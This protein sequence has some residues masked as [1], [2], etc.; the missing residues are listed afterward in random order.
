[1]GYL[2]VR[3]SHEPRY[4]DIGPSPTFAINA[5][6]SRKTEK[7]NATRFRHMPVAFPFFFF[8]LPVGVIFP[9]HRSRAKVIGEHGR[10]DQKAGASSA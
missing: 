2:D 5:A 3:V 4:W 9:R 10:D 6:P 8:C 7:V 1:M